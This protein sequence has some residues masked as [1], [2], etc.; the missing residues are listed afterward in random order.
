MTTTKE[1]RM[2]KAKATE[3]PVIVTTEHRGVFFGYATAGRTHALERAAGR[4]E[5]GPPDARET[6]SGR[7]ARRAGSAPEERHCSR[8]KGQTP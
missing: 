3:R 1:K 6:S 4:A 7:R 2:T 5:N 8:V